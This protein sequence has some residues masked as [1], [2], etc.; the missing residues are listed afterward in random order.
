MDTSPAA[1]IDEEEMTDDDFNND[2]D[3]VSGQTPGGPQRMSTLR[4]KV[5]LVTTMT[6]VMI[7]KRSGSLYSQKVWAH[8]PF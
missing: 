5:W 2:P 3:W 1:A 8:T 4:S 7:R 6:L